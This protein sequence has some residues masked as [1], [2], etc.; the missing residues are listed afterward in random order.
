MAAEVYIPGVESKG[1]AVAAT[2]ELAELLAQNHGVCFPTGRY[3]SARAT[4]RGWPRRRSR[5]PR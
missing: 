4:M 5:G 1:A 2:A 3:S